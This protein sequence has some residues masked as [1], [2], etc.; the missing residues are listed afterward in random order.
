MS[1]IKSIE[2]SQF[3]GI[4]QLEVSGFSRI[5]LIVGDNNS[6]KTTFLEAIQLLFAEA[7]LRSVNSIVRQRTVLKNQN[8]SFYVSFIN[9][10]NADQKEKTLSF[11][12]SAT[13]A[14]GSIRFE[15]A[16]VEKTVSGEEALRVSSMSS[17]QKS[18]YKNSLSLPP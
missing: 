5:N 10:F 3:R 18:S 1:G 12:I 6:G 13:G 11:D 15:I 2:I 17:R 16:G 9:L 4:K 14:D 8:D 7:N